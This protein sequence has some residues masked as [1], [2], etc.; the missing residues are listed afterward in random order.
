[1]REACGGTKG[2]HR[3]NRKR[4]CKVRQGFDFPRGK[5]RSPN[6]EET[7]DA[8]TAP[9]EDETGR[10]RPSGKTATDPNVAKL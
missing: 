2:K 1:M 4:T 10:E 8:K 5:S 3:G 9:H 6:G 7:N